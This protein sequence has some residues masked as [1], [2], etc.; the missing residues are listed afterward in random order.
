MQMAGGAAGSVLIAKVQDGTLLP[1]AL[2]MVLLAA[3]A[4]LGYRRFRALAPA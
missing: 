3:V 4:G 2:M 1:L